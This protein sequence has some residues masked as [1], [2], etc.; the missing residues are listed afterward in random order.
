MEMEERRSFYDQ[1]NKFQAPQAWVEFA[2]EIDPRIGP[3]WLVDDPSLSRSL[4]DGGEI[5]VNTRSEY[6][7]KYRSVG[8]ASYEEAVVFRFLHEIGHIVAGH[9]GTTDLQV[10]SKGISEEFERKIRKT[11]LVDIL[12]DPYEKQAW[13]YVRSIKDNQPEKFGCLLES[14]KVWQRAHHET[15]T[16]N[17]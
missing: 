1:L 17:C 2:R 11:S 13:D 7:E 15:T 4:R 5:F 8:A 16:K 9:T 14:F 10:D 3:I 12:K 6:W